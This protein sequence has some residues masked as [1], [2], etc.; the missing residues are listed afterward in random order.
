MAVVPG[1]GAGAVAVVPG[2]GAAVV[3]ITGAGCSTGGA[4]C[5]IGGSSGGISSAFFLHEKPKPK[6]KASVK[7]INP[8]IHLDIPFSTSYFYFRF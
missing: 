1:I 5:S 6:A 3:P 2:A 8:F 4:G 7:T